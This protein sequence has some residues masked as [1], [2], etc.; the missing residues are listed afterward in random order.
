M[1]YSWV[2]G[3]DVN[4]DNIANED[5]AYIPLRND[6][7]VGYGSA[8]QDQ[9]NA[10]QAFIDSDPYLRTHRGQIASRNSTYQ[11]WS[12]QLDLGLQQEFPGIF[13]GNK[14]IV[15]LDIFNFLNMTLKYHVE[16]SPDYV[17]GP[18]AWGNV[19][20]LQ[21]GLSL[22]SR[23]KVGTDKQTLKRDYDHVV[24]IRSRAPWARSR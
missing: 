11:P 21:A 18:V 6:P 2:F 8:T 13:K 4:G 10:F 24:T 16:G 23:D 22:A 9:I 17:D 12:N 19:D 15:R 1:P 20:A 7:L 14:S 5:L 3:T